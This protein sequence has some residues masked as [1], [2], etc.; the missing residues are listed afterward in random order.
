MLAVCLQRL[1]EKIHRQMHGA[2]CNRFQTAQKEKCTD[3]FSFVYAAM[4]E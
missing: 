3:R 2:T 4:Q 1:P